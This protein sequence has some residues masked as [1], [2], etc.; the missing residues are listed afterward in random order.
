MGWSPAPTQL[1]GYGLS[2][3]SYGLRTKIL[4]VDALVGS[5]PNLFEAHPEVS[6]AAMA[7]HPMDHAKKSWNGAVERLKT[8]SS[9]GIQLPF[10]KLRYGD[11][12]VDDVIDAAAVAWTAHRK[13]RGEARTWPA[14]PDVQYEGRPVAIWY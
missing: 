5:H 9:A 10:A 2:Q 8:L 4:E 3:Q 7:G 6:F 11:A 13:S 14:E 1:A 12:G